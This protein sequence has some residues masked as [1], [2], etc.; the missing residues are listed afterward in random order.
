MP[1]DSAVRLALA[2]IHMNPVLRHLLTQYLVEFAAM[3]GSDVK[4]DTQG[5]VPYRYFD[6]YWSESERFPFGIWVG[7]ELCGFYLLRDSEEQWNIAEFFV[8]CRR[9]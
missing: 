7:D 8:A 1:E 2:L 5:H 3:E 9:S 6:Q 4:R